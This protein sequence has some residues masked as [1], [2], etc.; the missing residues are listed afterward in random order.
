MKKIFFTFLLIFGL[1][2][3]NA[4]AHSDDLSDVVDSVLPGTVFV[5]SNNSNGLRS[6]SGSGTGFFIAQ[7]YIVTNF[8]VVIDADNELFVYMNDNIQDPLEVDLV[9]YDENMDIAVLALPP[10]HNRDVTVLLW[11]DSTQLRLLE[12]VFAI[13]NPLGLTWTVTSGVVSSIYRRLPNAGP[14]SFI[15]TDTPINRGNSGG[16]LFNSNGEVIGINTLV[17]GGGPNMGGRDGLGFAIT[18]HLAREVVSD[19]IQH[20][21]YR[22]GTLSFVFEVI[23]DNIVI[24]RLVPNGTV[25]R[26]NLIE[27]DIILEIDGRPIENADHLMIMIEEY[28]AGDEI[29]ITFERKGFVVEREITLNNRYN[30]QDQIDE[31]IDEIIREEQDRRLEEERR[32]LE[33]ELTPDIEEALEFEEPELNEDLMF[34]K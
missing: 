6:G 19:I 10:N 5:V 33:E 15:Q 24:R 32:E 3:P 27:G 9:G 7:N 25:D 29:T 14:A 17:L 34:L 1:T 2:V 18:S 30:E 31:L 13:G 20:G 28:H 11:G 4:I 8:H 22:P 12:P 16:P 26:A 23:D 21:E